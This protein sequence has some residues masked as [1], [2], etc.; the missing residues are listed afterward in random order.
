MA[1]WPYALHCNPVKIARLGSSSPSPDTILCGWLG[2][3]HQLTNILAPPARPHTPVKARAKD[4][5]SSCIC[6]ST[7]VQSHQRLSYLCMYSKHWDHCAYQRSIC[8]P[9]SK[10]RP[11]TFTLHLH[12]PLHCGG[13]WGTTDDFT[14]SSLHFSLSCTA[15]LDLVKSRPV[16]SLM[17]SSHLFF[18]LPC[19]LFPLTVPCKMVLVRPDE[20]ETCPEHLSLRLSLMV[21]WSS[22][23]PIAC[24]IFA[25]TSSLVTWSLYEKRSILWT[26]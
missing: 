11:N 19:L 8:P 22:C 24:W 7:L 25:Q 4:L 14:T 6:T 20:Q 9:F 26:D 10:R 16:H 21:R 18:C 17:L 12:L 5:F 3:K 13:R 2:S 23:G 15:L 1:K